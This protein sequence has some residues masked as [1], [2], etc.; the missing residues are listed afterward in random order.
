M[1]IF[2]AIDLKGGQCA[3]LKKGDFSNAT[4]YG[5]DPVLQAQKFE[6]QGATWLHVVDLDGAKDGAARQTKLIET[7]IRS[8]SLRVQVGGGIRSARDIEVLLN[9]GA[10]RVVIG[11]LA[12]AQ[13]NTVRGWADMFGDERIVLALDIRLD[14]KNKPKI[15]TRGWQD[16]SQK[17]LWDILAQYENGGTK[18]VLCTDVERDGTLAGPNLDLYSEIKKRFPSFDILASGGIACLDDIR[19]LAKIRAAGAITGKALYEN[20]FA[21]SEAL[22][23]AEN[24]G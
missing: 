21:F 19:A 20:K 18:T 12:V 23:E 1:D 16:N 6:G 2:P 7:I 13:P 11:S 10:R 15:L 22:Q 17:T 24:V 14:E 3:R 8:T 5:N 4:V 9:C